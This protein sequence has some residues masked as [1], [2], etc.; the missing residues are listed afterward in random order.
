MAQTSTERTACDVMLWLDDDSGTP[1]DISGSAASVDMSFTN[2]VG[3]FR[4]FGGRWT[5]RTV[6]GSD[7]SFTLNVVYTTATGESYDVI[8][9]WWTGLQY[10]DDRSLRIQVPDNEA[11]SEQW[12]M[13]VVLESWDMT[14]D[15]SEGGPIMVTANVLPNGAV[16]HGTIGS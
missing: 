16:V 15:S 3:D 5:K 1:T 2:N 9:D 10:A 7:A 4:T 13:E 12:D 8:R 6:C 11:N 14:L